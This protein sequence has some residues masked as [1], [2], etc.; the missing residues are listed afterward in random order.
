MMKHSMKSKEKTSKSASFAKGGS[1]KMSGKNYVGPQQPGQSASAG[2]KSNAP[3]AKA[4]GK[5][6]AGFSGAAP[7]A[8]GQVST[9]GR[10]GNSTFAPDTGGKAMAG[11]TGS[12][13][14]KCC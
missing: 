5:A 7:A 11:F 3:I 9:G 1:T 10:G 8:A 6:M 14:A 12:Q 4:G 2:Q 13:N